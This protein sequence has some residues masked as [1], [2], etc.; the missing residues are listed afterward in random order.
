MAREA[1]EQRGAPKA[2]GGSG[3]LDRWFRLREAGTDVRTEVIAGIVTFMTMA[4]IIFVNPD[5]LGAAGVPRQA[6]AVA[7]ALGAG[8]MTILMGLASNYPLALASGMGLNAVLAFGVVLGAGYTW[9][10]AMGIVFWEGL[11]VTLLV[12]T[13]ARESVMNAIPAN[14]KRAIGVGIGLFIAFIGLKNAGIITHTATIVPGPG[15]QPVISNP[16]YVALGNLREPA[17]LL[18]LFGLALTLLLVVRRVRGALLLGILGT[19][20][21]AFFTGQARLPETWL[22]LPTAESLATIGRLDFSVVLNLSAWSFI[23]AFLMTDFFDTM[24]TVVAVGGEAG[25]LRPDGTVPRLR[26]VLLVDSLAAVTGGFLG[27][28]SIT[29]YIESASGVGEGGRTGLT[30]VVTGLL[31]LL[32]IFF[33]PVVG[34]VPSAATAPALIIVG[35]LMMS[36][37]REIEFGNPEDGIPAFLTLLGMPLTFNISHGIGLGFVSYVLLKLFRGRA[38]D[39]HPLL[40]VVS[41]LFTVELFGLWQFI[42]R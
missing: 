1:L 41:A 40:W 11:L 9:Q 14:L 22:S 20:L 2:V 7:T 5:I 27:C 13:G 17:A 35:F 29:T 39:V 38:R 6:A 4:Y 15:G 31:F 3:A 25:Y 30:S 28:S 42:F 33:A 23:F 37:V 24:G 21:V 19:T 18:A 26:N 36:V 8:V 34:I 16:T 12:L 32:A 10:Q